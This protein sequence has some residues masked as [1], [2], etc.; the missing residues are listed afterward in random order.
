M[1]DICKYSPEYI[2]SKQQSIKKR[3]TRQHRTPYK[4]DLTKP[5]VI[6]KHIY[7]VWHNLENIP[8]CVKQSVDTLKQQNPEFEH[9]LYDEPK[10]REYISH[11]CSPQILNAYDK[12]V[13]HAL[14]ADLWRYCILYNN[15]G[16]YLDSKYYGINGFKFIHLLD[17]EYFCNGL[18]TI[19]GVYNAIFICKPH[20]PI[21]LK[22]INQFVKNT[23]KK[24][25]GT[26]ELCIG[27]LMIQTFFT[28]QE[29]KLFPLKLERV[30][31]R[32][33]YITLNG[34]RI[35]KYNEEYATS[36]TIK[37]KHWTKYWYSKTLYN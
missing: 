25:Y 1:I 16:I 5:Q 36:K 27:P 10:C 23:E 32:Y 24:Y 6:P 12:I 31:K 26:N 22:V 35:L 37:N 13:P 19:Y 28:P 29:T 33:K 15:G 34:Y 8:R 20:N 14:K 21:L 7:Q 18:D 4:I 11:Y 9:H 2:K 3:K 17:K 30:S